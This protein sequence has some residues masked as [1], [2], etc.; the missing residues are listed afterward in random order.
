[1][2]Q[3]RHH[4]F[5]TLRRVDKQPWFVGVQQWAGYENVLSAGNL[6]KLQSIKSWFMRKDVDGMVTHDHYR[7][8][9]LATHSYFDG[10]YGN[11]SDKGRQCIDQRTTDPKNYHP[12][13]IAWMWKQGI[14]LSYTEFL[15]TYFPLC[16][17]VDIADHATK[18]RHLSLAMQRDILRDEIFE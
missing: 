13:I 6:R 17:D 11:F 9:L 3:D 18:F 8:K 10:G 15:S 12:E 14:T 4:R 1:M 7:G 5:E 2:C 16:F